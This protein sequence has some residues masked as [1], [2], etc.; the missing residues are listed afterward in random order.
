M[1]FCLTLSYL[2]AHFTPVPSLLNGILDGLLNHGDTVLLE[3]LH[4]RVVELAVH[5]RQ[6]TLLADRTIKHLLNSHTAGNT[7]GLGHGAVTLRVTVLAQGGR[8]RLL[9]A[10]LVLNLELVLQHDEVALAGLKLHLLLE[11][12]AESIER[13]AAGDGLL[14]GEESDP[15]QTGDKTGLLLLTGEVGLGLDG[16]R[17]VSLA[18][19]LGGEDLGSG[20]LPGDGGG[21][22]GGGLVGE[23]SHVDEDLD[24]SGEALVTQSTADDGLALGDVVALLVW[25]GIAVRVGNKGVTRVDEVWLGSSHQ[26]LTLNLDNLAILVVLGSIAK[27]E[28]D[29]T[30]RPGE[31]VSQRVVRVLWGWESTAV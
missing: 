13:V 23:E 10:V 7:D 8:P 29:T 19:G 11:R 12:G 5:W 15:L 3:L 9:A 26:L 6:H 1:A 30:G 31:L 25:G 22:V 18:A 4:Q 14:V 27:S 28:E 21:E 17:E 16:C 20:I 2:I 24:E